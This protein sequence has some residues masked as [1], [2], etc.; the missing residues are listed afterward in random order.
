MCV[1]RSFR[2]SRQLAAAR[3]IVARRV[4][5]DEVASGTTM[6]W[7]L[8]FAQESDPSTLP[9]AIVLKNLIASLYPQ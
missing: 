9:R 8:R 5:H 4:R 7:S 1:I 3:A 6:G 2:A